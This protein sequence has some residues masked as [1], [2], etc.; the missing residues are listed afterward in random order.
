MNTQY[1]KNKPYVSDLPYK[2]NHGIIIGMQFSMNLK[3]DRLDLLPH[4][5][6]RRVIKSNIWSDKIRKPK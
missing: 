6:E 5:F 1:T 3:L 4:K 2:M